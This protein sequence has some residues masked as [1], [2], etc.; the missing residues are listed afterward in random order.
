MTPAPALDP[1][2]AVSPRLRTALLLPVLLL[3]SLAGVILA[4]PSG[5]GLLWFVPYA[6]VGTLLVTRGRGGMIGWLLLAL[7]W[8]HVV[9]SL[10]IDVGPAG[11]ADGRAGPLITAVAVISGGPAGPTLFLTYVVLMAVL[12]SGRLPSG[13]W[14]RLFRIVLVVSGLAIVASTFGATI[15]LNWSGSTNALAMP[16]PV[17]IAPGS[18]ISQALGSGSLTFPMVVLLVAGIVAFVRRFRRSAGVERQQLRWI[19]AA[20]TLLVVSLMGGFLV[21]TLVPVVG[22]TGVQWL[23]VALSFPLVPVSIGIAV[24]RYRLY[25]IDRIVS[26][27]I[28]WT[29]VTGVLVGAFWLLVVGLQDLLAPVTS[30]STL[31]VAVSTL[32]V[33]AV[34]QPLRR[35]VQG[36]VDRRFDRA[37]YDGDR[38][39]LRFADQLRDE[40]GLDAI[41]RELLSTVDLAVRPSGAGLW[42]RTRGPGGAA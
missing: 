28:A 17:A 16:N 24:L 7:G 22:E 11:F 3:T 26:R 12:P 8:L 14:G 40:V 21:G 30:E 33:A 13:V 39:A 29:A 4:V 31:A 15:S 19:V 2:R 5:F 9:V 38:L 37:R 25:E 6:L 42:L 32:A 35:R 20:L 18:E 34:F 36:A 23:P 27:T 41:S 1:A 10:P